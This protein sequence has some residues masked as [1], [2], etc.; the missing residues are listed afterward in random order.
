M[1]PSISLGCWAVVVEQ[2]A[3]LPDELGHCIFSHSWQPVAELL[4]HRLGGEC[5]KTYVERGVAV[6]LYGW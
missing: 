4:W 5:G 3:A 2:A 6:Q 1:V